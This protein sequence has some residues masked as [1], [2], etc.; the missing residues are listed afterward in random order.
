MHDKVLQFLRYP[1]MMYFIQ[2]KFGNPS[3]LLLEELL[4][5][6]MGIPQTV[7]AKAFAS[8]DAKTPETLKELR[9]SFLDLVSDKYFIRCPEV[10]S[11]TVPKLKVNV[12]ELFL[13]P[14]IDLNELKEII[15]KA[16]DPTD[17]VKDK[18]YWTVNFDRFHQSFRDKILVDC[19][20]RQI[21]SNAAECFQFI[22][23]LMYGKTDPW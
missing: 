2:K 20:E 1:K 14:N 15:D 21:D 9:D 12:H 8:S 7:I 10:T 16:Q 17:V 23:N 19:I 22:I 13:V 4:K 3:A 6:G 11:D 18:I 5:C